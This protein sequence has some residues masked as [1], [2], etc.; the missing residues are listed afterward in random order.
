MARVRGQK[1]VYQ[2]WLYDVVNFTGGT[3]FTTASFF[4]VQQGQSGKTRADTNVITPSS[5]T[6]VNA[7][8][9]K[10]YVLKMED[11]ALTQ[12][13]KRLQTTSLTL[14]VN[15]TPVPDPIPWEFIL[16]GSTLVESVRGV[17]A[18]PEFRA[19]AGSGFVTNAL[20]FVNPGLVVLDPGDTYRADLEAPAAG[21]VTMDENMRVRLILFGPRSKPTM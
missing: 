2:G 15:D 10:S 1:T 5:F 4:T 8:K 18:A 3:P 6:G 14:F 19:V 16:G 13:A 11:L 12:D 7:L 17:A 20:T 21:G 9:I